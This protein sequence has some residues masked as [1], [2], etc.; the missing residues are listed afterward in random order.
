MASPTTDAPV[1]SELRSALL[2]LT[3]DRDGDDYIVGRP[4][5][6]IYVTIPRP[7]VV[8]IEAL[9]D[10]APLAEATA[11]ASD[12]AGEEVDGSDFLTGLGG[13]G[14]LDSS[15]GESRAI[16]VGTHIGWI[17]KIPQ[18]ALTPLFGRVAWTVYAAAL[19]GSV[20]LLL[21][22][23]PDLQPIFDDIWF[24]TDPIWSMLV[25][26]VVSAVITMGHECWH[27]LAGRA[28]GVTARFRVSWRGVFVVFESDLSQLVT[29]PRRARYSPLLA[30]FAFDGMVLA[31]ALLVRLGYREEFLS[32]PPLL[33]RLLGAIV[34][35]QIVVLV[36]QLSGVA[37]RSDTYAVLANA[38]RC[39]NLYRATS[40]TVKRGVWRMSGA[41]ADELAGMGARDRS[42]AAWFWLVYVAGG[43]FMFW[44]AFT[45]LVPFTYGMLQWVGP[46][47]IEL[48]PSSFVFWQSLAL[49]VLLV[50]QFAV[51][52]FIARRERRRARRAGTAVPTGT[53][54]RVITSPDR[55]AW[56]AMFAFLAIF[57]LIA[58]GSHL[59]G[60]F[61]V[62]TDATSANVAAAAVDDSCLPGR[63]I[64]ILDYPHVSELALAGAVYNSNPPTSGAHYGAAVAP[65][66][67]SSY[68]P[69]GV[70]VHAMEHGRVVIHYRPDTA[71]SVVD[72]L[73][74]IAKQFSRDTVLHP[75]PELD[76]QIA[77]TAWGRIDTLD[78]FD[79][80]EIVEF[81]DTF[82]N[83]Y[84][85]R[86]TIT[87]NECQ[88][89][90]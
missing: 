76:T 20:L 29:L 66:I 82:R 49:V 74:S 52:P 84:N 11:L 80:A 45:Y 38:L 39:H 23:R 53:D 59:Q 75:N 31:A 65:G 72:E 62:S 77:L 47:L 22:L 34:F 71:Q 79:R 69:P 7:G 67:Y 14:L 35:R 73:V 4:D 87:G 41:E 42:A 24:L 85:H 46:N 43:F 27:W 30:G 5:L 60:Y 10:G 54:T 8:L 83:R 88:A 3:V 9:R 33:D 15:D 25:L 17:D 78:R 26:F 48:A 44:V 56:R 51:V 36:W 32:I 28:L 19:L 18:R 2:S 16:V 81:V 13:A 57:A 55:L 37:F 64:P 21:V 58:T 90:P 6:G 89:A 70:T 12:E 61:G 86:S 63:Q 1:G 40:L 50:G 68:L